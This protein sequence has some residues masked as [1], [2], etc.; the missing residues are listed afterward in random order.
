MTLILQF[1][2]SAPAVPALS[3]RRS[4]VLVPFLG[5]T[6]LEHALSGFAAA[7]VKHIQLA[8]PR[9]ADEHLLKW[10]GRGEVWGL[11]ITSASDPGKDNVPGE[12][13]EVVLD[14]LPQLPGV[15]LWR[16]YRSWFEAQQALMA[17]FAQ[18]RVGMRQVAD[19]VFVGFRSKVAPD[20][21]LE[22]PC[23]V[24]DNVFLGSRTVVGPSSIIENGSYLDDGAEVAGS[25]IGPETYV[26]SFAEVRNSFA[27]GAD[28]LQLDNGSLTEV[29]DRFIL[30]EAKSPK[31]SLGGLRKFFNMRQGSS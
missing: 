24:G 8:S 10:V 17:R 11:K 29:T 21:R 22:P 16:S 14:E 4:L 26:G 1:P 20:A 3:R 27:W 6:V 31:F 7:G 18:N 12:V 23:W 25:V 13:R 19:G 28:L 15:P 2:H 30:G 9:P 5:Q